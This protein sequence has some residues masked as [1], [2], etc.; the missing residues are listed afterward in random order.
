MT[1]TS[2]PLN[3]KDL[4]LRACRGESIP[5]LPVWMMRQAGRYLPEYRAIR[6][7]HAF[8][9]VCKTPDLAV[10]V[11]LQPFRVLGVDAVIVFSD[12]LIPAEAMGLKLE[13]GDAGPNLPEPVRSKRDIE[14]LKLFDPE[15]ETGF[16]PEA[17]RSIVREV[18]PTVPV[19]GFA[20]APWTLACYMVEGRT[21]EGFATVKSFMLSEPATFRDLL[22]RIAQ[23]TIPYLKAQIAA[24]VAAVQLFDTWCGEL[25]LRDYEEFALPATQEIISGLGSATPIIYYTKASHHLLPAVAHSGASVL[26]VDWRVDMRALREKLGPRIAIQ[27]NVD[28]AVLFGPP[29]EIRRVTQEAMAALGGVGHILN[30]G[31]GILQHTPI[32]NAKLF[33]ET[34][35]QTLLQ[36]AVAAG[37]ALPSTRGTAS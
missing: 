30:L 16:L 4:F 23:A 7:N 14:K 15:T 29:D 22:H 10:E 2:A 21:K 17:I 37:L 27:G 3:R 8:L 12:I 32:E 35:Q 11:S 26:S 34:G 6:A 19:L 24:G 33:I 20:A 28:P 18:G 36:E 1:E 25:S 13:L 5:R 31:H 9:E